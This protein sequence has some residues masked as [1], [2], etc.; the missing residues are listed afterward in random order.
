[1][2]W[3][4][5]V[6]GDVYVN[7]KTVDVRNRII[8]RCTFIVFRLNDSTTTITQSYNRTLKTNNAIFVHNWNTFWNWIYL[9]VL[10]SRFSNFRCVF[11]AHMSSV[12][13]ML[14]WRSYCRLCGDIAHLFLCAISN[15]SVCTRFGNILPSI[16]F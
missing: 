10:I 1:M 15:N 7:G 12:S 13:V 16:R 14:P 3:F 4:Y 11:P 5:F 2:H 6:H 8:Q 9:L